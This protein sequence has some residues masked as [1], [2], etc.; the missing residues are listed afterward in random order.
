MNLL[1]S[2]QPRPISSR[3]TQTFSARRV[4]VALDA[5]VAATAV[6]GGVACDWNGAKALFRRAARRDPIPELHGARPAPGGGGRGTSLVATVATLRN[7]RGGP[8]A[9]A[10]AGATLVGWIAGEVCILPPETHSWIELAYAAVG[11]AMSA[12]GL[13]ELVKSG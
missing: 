13:K 12:V 2:Q 10:V 7:R 8:L 11:L 5:F 4:L 6:A 3:L 1:T 9:S